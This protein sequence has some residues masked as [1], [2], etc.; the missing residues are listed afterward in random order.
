[1]FGRVQTYCRVMR[2]LCGKYHG[3]GPASRFNGAIAI[4]NPLLDGSKRIGR[5]IPTRVSITMECRA[6]LQKPVNYIHFK[7]VPKSG[8]QHGA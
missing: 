2:T 8:A 4:M 1:V 5:Y 7:R 3:R 6:I